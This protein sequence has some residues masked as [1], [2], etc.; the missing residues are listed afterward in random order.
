MSNVAVNISLS[1]FHRHQLNYCS[2]FEYHKKITSE[3]LH[4]KTNQSPDSEHFEKRRRA[5][6]GHILRSNYPTKDFLAYGPSMRSYQRGPSPVSIL[7]TYKNGV[8][9]SNFA[10]L[11]TLA[12][13]RRLWLHNYH[14]LILLPGSNFF[15]KM[16]LFFRY[17]GVNATNAVN[18]Q[19][20]RH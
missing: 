14:S 17:S 5:Y 19:A 18:L 9:T 20:K 12:A 7:K 4:E 15:G 6:L 13:A 16:P 1:S 2:N 8:G 3:D 10:T 11:F